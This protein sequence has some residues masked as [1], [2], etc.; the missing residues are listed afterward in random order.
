M[1]Q[2]VAQWDAASVLWFYDRRKASLSRIMTALTRIGDGYVWAGMGIS[3]GFL[4]SKGPQ[5]ILLLAAAFVIELS[6]YGSIKRFV[7]RL[8]PFASLPGVTMLVV[9]PDEFSFPSGHTAAAF[10]MTTMFAVWYP[11]FL[12]FMLPLALSIGVSRVYLAVHYP[13]DVIAGAAL[14]IVSSVLALAI[15]P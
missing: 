8:R 12:V 13:S 6:L 9:P 4:G 15:V 5:I 10:V 7:S 1:L 3:V 11:M 2:S 14:G